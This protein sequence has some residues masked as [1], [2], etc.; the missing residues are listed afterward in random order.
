M[1]VYWKKCNSFYKSF[2][3]RCGSGDWTANMATGFIQSIENGEHPHCP[4]SAAG[5]SAAKTG[6]SALGI[7]GPS[8]DMSSEV[9]VRFCLRLMS[10]RGYCS[11]YAQ[12]SHFRL[13]FSIMGWYFFSCLKALYFISYFFFSTPTSIFTDELPS[14]KSSISSTIEWWERQDQ[15]EILPARGH[16]TQE[17]RGWDRWDQEFRYR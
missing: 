15:T 13:K 6:R 8:S 1:T 16:Q 10:Q 11:F 17:T 4:P 9:L 7:H 2:H 14:V 3:F 12:M 5:T